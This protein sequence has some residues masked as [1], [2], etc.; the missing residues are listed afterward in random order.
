VLWLLACATALTV[1]NM[2]LEAARST[3]ERATAAELR[4]DD[5]GAR[6]T[7]NSHARVSPADT[8]APAVVREP[9][10]SKPV[11]ARRAGCASWRANCS[12]AALDVF[13]TWV[14]DRRSDIRRVRGGLRLPSGGKT[15]E[16]EH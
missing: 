1:A 2:G 9:L 13:E 10:A 12:F 6:R 16:P 7:A 8:A 11:A 15:D 3:T 14:P 4:D 5:G